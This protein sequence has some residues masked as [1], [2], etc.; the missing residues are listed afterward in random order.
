MLLTFIDRPKKIQVKNK[1][2]TSLLQQCTYTL[3]TV[4]SGGGLYCFRRSLFSLWPR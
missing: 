1:M 4:R 2:D 3:V